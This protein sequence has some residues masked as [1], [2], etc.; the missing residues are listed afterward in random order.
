MNKID[1]M[2]II[3]NTNVA[4]IISDSSLFRF[5]LNFSDKLP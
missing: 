5:N 1:V 2:Q 3:V 4:A